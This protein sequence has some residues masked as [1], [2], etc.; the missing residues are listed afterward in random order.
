MAEQSRKTDRS[1]RHRDFVINLS[2]TFHVLQA[3]N[4]NTY[5]QCTSPRTMFKRLPPTAGSDQPHR[6]RTLLTESKYTILPRPKGKEQSHE[7]GNQKSDTTPS[8]PQHRPLQERQE[9]YEK[10][11]AWIFGYG[12]GFLTE[13]YPPLHSNLT[14][15][16]STT[17]PP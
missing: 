14:T 17:Y 5:P 15:H 6:N 2:V 12:G 8:K 4:N 7:W 11:R 10:T 9:V 13:Y 1:K 3:R 16:H